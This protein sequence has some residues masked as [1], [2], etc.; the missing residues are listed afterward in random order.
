M[1]LLVVLL[2][3]AF[4]TICARRVAQPGNGISLVLTQMRHK[5]QRVK[6]KENPNKP[7]FITKDERNAKKYGQ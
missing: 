1:D 6:A 2:N 5:S 4:K 3:G 7:K